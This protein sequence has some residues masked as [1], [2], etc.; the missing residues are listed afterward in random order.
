MKKILLGSLVATS[1]LMGSNSVQVN[2]NQ[3]TLEFGADL[4]LNDAFD[5][6]NDTNYYFTASHLRTEN[7][8][9]STQSLSTAGFKL[10]NP[11]TDDNGISLG[12]GMKAVYTNQISQNF[13]ALPLTVNGRIELSEVLYIDGEI[14]YAPKVLAFADG[15][16]YTDMKAR[17]NYKVL[18]DGYVYVGARNIKTKY[19]NSVEKTY[20]SSAFIGF[21]FR[22]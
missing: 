10:V 20:D 13:V 22:F 12:I 1:L 19:D 4:Y 3:D 17:V 6:S 5:V 21:E 7:D 8:N 11:M 16:R 18:A 2:V 9:Q 15:E 14:S